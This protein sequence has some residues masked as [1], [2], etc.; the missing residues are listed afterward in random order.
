M[1]DSHFRVV[2]HLAAGSFCTPYCL[3]PLS[4]I[5]N[6]SYNISLSRPALKDLDSRCPGGTLNIFAVLCNSPTG[7][8]VEGATVQCSAI[9]KRRGL[10]RSSF[11]LCIARDVSPFTRFTAFLLC[12]V[13]AGLAHIHAPVPRHP[14]LVD[15]FD[16]GVLPITILPQCYAPTRPDLWDPPSLELSK[17][18]KTFT[19]AKRKSTMDERGFEP[20][21]FHK[22]TV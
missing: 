15:G 21:T 16:A 18:K 9:L 5:T 22:Y 10:G 13:I 19:R 1:V 20:R 8:Q 4:A 17:N 7:D 6:S 11:D 12:S 2:A 14:A 3:P